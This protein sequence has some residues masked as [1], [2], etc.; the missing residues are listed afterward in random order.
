MPVN[1]RKSRSITHEIALKHLVRNIEPPPSL[2][3][4]TCCSQL[5]PIAMPGVEEEEQEVGVRPL[6]LHRGHLP[7]DSV[8]SQIFV[9]DLQEMIRSTTKSICILLAPLGRCQKDLRLAASEIGE[10]T[11]EETMSLESS[12]MAICTLLI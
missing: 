11:L 12:S 3:K 7:S 8:G 10:A 5:K 9:W 6:K 1:A 4:Q 2:K